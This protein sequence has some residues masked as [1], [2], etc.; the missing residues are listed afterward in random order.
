MDADTLE[1]IR[2]GHE[3]FGNAAPAPFLAD[4]DEAQQGQ[5]LD[6]HSGH[7]GSEYAARHQQ[8]GA[9]LRMGGERDA[10]VREVITRVMDH[11]REAHRSSKSVL[12]AAIA[13][14]VPPAE[15]TPMGRRE[16]AER[17]AAYLRAQQDT[18][19][20][21]RVHAQKAA[22]ELRAINYRPA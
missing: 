4:I 2:R 5:G 10:Q 21:A 7:A 12:D 19:R 3:V 14:Q 18:V 13:D 8:H 11:Y 1:L 9:G 20:Q 22:E 17:A 16:A 15:D 6:G